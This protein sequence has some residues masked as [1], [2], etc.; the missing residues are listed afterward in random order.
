MMNTLVRIYIYNETKVDNDINDK[1]TVIPNI[2]PK[3]LRE[4]IHPRYLPRPFSVT[5]W[6]TAARMFTSSIS[7]SKQIVSTRICLLTPY[8]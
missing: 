6:S 1:F 5:D 4:D 8:H 2:I 3:T 7:T